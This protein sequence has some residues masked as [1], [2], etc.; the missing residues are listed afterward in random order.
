MLSWY[1]KLTDILE[2]LID[3]GDFDPIELEYFNTDIGYYNCKK[4]YNLDVNQ[5][6]LDRLEQLK[7]VYNDSFD[8]PLDE[9]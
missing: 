1:E 7:V 8:D 9:R 6:D 5:F 2:I 3:K 4:E